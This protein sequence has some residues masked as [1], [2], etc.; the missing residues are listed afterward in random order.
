LIL[1]DNIMAKARKKN[2][3]ITTRTSC[4]YPAVKKVSV[5]P[6][7]CLTEKRRKASTKEKIVYLI[8]EGKTFPFKNYYT[9]S[10]FCRGFFFV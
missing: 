2:G 9:T 8:T 10:D 4:L 3:Q 5:T 7:L 6:H 1:N